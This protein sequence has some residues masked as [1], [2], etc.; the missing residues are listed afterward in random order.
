MIDLKQFCTTADPR[1]IL[2]TPF[3]IGEWVYATDGQVLV[4]LAQDGRAEADL[5]QTPK[6]IELLIGAAHKN[7]VEW[8]PWPEHDG[9]NEFKPCTACRETGVLLVDCDECDGEGSIRCE[10]CGLLSRCR[11]CQGRGDKADPEGKPCQECGGSGRL[12]AEGG[13]KQRLPTGELIGSVNFKKIAS[14]PGAEYGAPK[15][16]RSPIPIR[17][18]GGIGCVMP[19]AERAPEAEG[20][21]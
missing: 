15:T 17:F 11:A 16:L 13:A 20:C 9:K 2:R 1:P 12:M 18:V 10:K 3:R 21:D 4:R 8:W 6:N 19:I 5:S 7:I 14:L